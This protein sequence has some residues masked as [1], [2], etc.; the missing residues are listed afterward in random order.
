MMRITVCATRGS[1][2]IVKVLRVR[3]VAVRLAR[4]LAALGFDT[5]FTVARA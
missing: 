4:S 3:K 2:A 1:T 5:S